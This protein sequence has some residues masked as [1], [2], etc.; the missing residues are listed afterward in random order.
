MNPAEIDGK[1]ESDQALLPATPEDVYNRPGLSAIRYRIGSYDSFREA[2]IKKISSYKLN[3]EEG[4]VLQA[5][6]S[7]DSDD[8][9]IALM[10]MWAYIGDI[11]TFYQ[12]R[13]ANEAYLRTAILPESI[14]RLASFLDYRPFPG[15]AATAFLAFTIEKDK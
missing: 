5:W 10:E 4:P 6:T 1:A 7:R 12:E 9:G 2:M 8:Y 11:L 13:I 15:I 14:R 3:A